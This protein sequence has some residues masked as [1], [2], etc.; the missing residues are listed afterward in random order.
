M[1]LR[2]EESH[3]VAW[4]GLSQKI[5]SDWNLSLSGKEVDR[6]LERSVFK[7][8]LVSLHK[9]AVVADLLGWDSIE[10]MYKAAQQNTTLSAK[11]KKINELLQECGGAGFLSLL[12]SALENQGMGVANYVCIQF[13][14]RQIRSLCYQNDQYHYELEHGKGQFHLDVVPKPYIFLSQLDFSLRH[15]FPSEEGSGS[16]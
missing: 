11:A 1:T 9:M 6:K 14:V 4:Q 15:P 16:P 7:V 5:S 2:T 8:F 13:S 3:G 10:E 12:Q